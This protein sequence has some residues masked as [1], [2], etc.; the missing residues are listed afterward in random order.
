MVTVFTVWWRWAATTRG[1]CWLVAE[2]ATLSTTAGDATPTGRPT[3]RPWLTVLSDSGGM[4]WEGRTVGSMWLPT[5]ATTTWWI[6]PPAHYA[7]ASS[8]MSLCGSSSSK[9]W[10][11]SSRRSSS[12]TASRPWTAEAATCTL[13]V[14]LVWPCSTSQTSLC[15][16]STSTI[17]SPPVQPRCAARRSISGIG[18]RRT[19]TPF[20]FTVPKTSGSTTTTSPTARMG[21]LISRKAP[22]PSPS[23]TTTSLTTTRW[24]YWARTH[25]T[26]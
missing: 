25:R 20:P 2:L 8:R 14:A 6:R 12:W 10:W 22:P 17:A 13:P 19:G 1:E 21:L 11:F 18:E 4:P 15:T 3:D 7:T 24:C 23:P 9:T 5:T 26:Q 16:V